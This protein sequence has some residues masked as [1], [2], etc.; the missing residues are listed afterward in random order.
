MTYNVRYMKYINRHDV[1]TSNRAVFVFGDNDTRSGMGGQAKE[2]RGEPN[3]I[4]IRVKK[5]PSMSEG[6]FY[7]DDEY[8]ENTRKIA[9]D[10]ENLGRVAY[11]KI[12]VFPED[13]VG[14]GMAML[15]RTAPRTF[16]YLTMAL[17]QMF[18]IKN[19]DISQTARLYTDIAKPLRP[20]RFAKIE[21]GDYIEFPL[22]K[23]KQRGTVK[24]IPYPGTE[25]ETY[26]VR[27]DDGTNDPMII[28]SPT[29]DKY[30]TIILD[31]GV[32]KTKLLMLRHKKRVSPKPKIIKRKQIKKTIKKS[33]K[34]CKCKK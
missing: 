15:N 16:D 32:P 33:I 34:R 18:G 25:K 2:M 30:N 8:I 4:G 7:T 21:V 27:L 13:G 14:T 5:S 12:I 1:K 22:G 23:T 6:S 3:A 31:K 19:G 10:L 26:V 28:K 17:Q 29:S 20:N 9:E 24:N 11:G